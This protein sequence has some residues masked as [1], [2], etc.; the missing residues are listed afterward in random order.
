MID[1]PIARILVPTDFSSGSERAWATARRLA[2]ALGAELLLLHVL[3]D[4]PVD[5]GPRFA[6]EERQAAER[7]AQ[8]AHQLGI[9]RAAADDEPPP[10]SV[11]AGPFTGDRMR[12]FSEAGREWAMK[13]EAWADGGR[14]DGLKV[15]SLLRVGVPYREILEAAKDERIDLIVLATHGRGEIQ[16]LLLGSVADRLVRLAACP[17]MTLRAA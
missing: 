17:V 2:G 10:P 8:A 9:P 5:L 11:F 15:A 1:G 13:L 3:P 12:E 7:A 16:R 4:T 6:R 14:R